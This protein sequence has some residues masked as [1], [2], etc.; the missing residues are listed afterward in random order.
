MRCDAKRTN[1]ILCSL[2]DRQCGLLPPMPRSRK[3]V[4]ERSMEYLSKRAAEDCRLI[5]PSLCLPPTRKRERNDVINRPR[6]EWSEFS[7]PSRHEWMEFM[8]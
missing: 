2:L 8:G 5:K 6:E 3:C 1:N 7:Y 4:H